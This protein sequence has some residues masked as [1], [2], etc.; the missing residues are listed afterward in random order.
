MALLSD[1]TLDPQ[2][3]VATIPPTRTLDAYIFLISKRKPPNSVTFPNLFLGTIWR[4]TCL[5]IKFATTF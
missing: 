2:F 4:S 5:S 1:G 3:P